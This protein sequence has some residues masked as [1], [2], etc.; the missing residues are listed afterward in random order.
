M[1]K[2]LRLLTVGKSHKFA[3]QY[4]TLKVFGEIYFKNYACIQL[5]VK[6]VKTSQELMVDFVPYESMEHGHREILQA[7]KTRAEREQVYHSLPVDAKAVKFHQAIRFGLA[8][9]FRVYLDHTQQ[10]HGLHV[11]VVDVVRNLV[12]DDEIMAYVTIRALWNSLNFEPQQLPH[13]DK[14]KEVFIY[15]SEHI[16]HWRKKVFY[17]STQNL[18][19]KLSEDD[20]ITM[21]QKLVK[22]KSSSPW[23]RDERYTKYK[24]IGFGW[25]F[26]SNLYFDNTFFLES[27]MGTFHLDNFFMY[28]PGQT[29]P[30]DQNVIVDKYTG[31][32]VKL[33][34]KTK[35][36]EFV[37]VY[38][39]EKG[40]V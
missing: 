35:L 16:P 27:L 12:T 38:K 18:Q 8:Y 13:F 1:K 25:L 20:A 7:C 37:E 10:N 22:V 11:K 28:P 5:E 29:P 3:H 31:E 17:Q 4:L 21:V 40:Y 26:T 6:K 15:D 39:Q 24:D 30:M 34:P 32:V 2:L 19:V 23:F 33:P 14:K 9:A 36:K